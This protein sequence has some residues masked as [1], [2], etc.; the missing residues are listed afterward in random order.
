VE[1]QWSG[2]GRERGGVGVAWFGQKRSWVTF[3]IRNFGRGE[4]KVSQKT[5]ERLR[6]C[7]WVNKKSPSSRSSFQN[8]I[9]LAK[10]EV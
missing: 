5:A 1:W 7:G 2:V 4:A 9:P 8:M 6:E 10:A 3:A